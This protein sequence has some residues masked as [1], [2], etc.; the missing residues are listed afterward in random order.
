MQWWQ[1]GRGEFIY[2]LLTFFPFIL[3]PSEVSLLC[4]IESQKKDWR[5]KSFLLFFLFFLK[6]KK[7]R[8]TF[9][10]SYRGLEWLDNL[11]G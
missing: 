3:Q 6:K 11:I 7:K 1:G 4:Y 2:T 10:V 5:E 9:P 8:G